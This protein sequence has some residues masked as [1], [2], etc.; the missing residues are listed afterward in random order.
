MMMVMVMMIMMII[1]IIIIIIINSTTKNSNIGH[2]T[3]TTESTDVQAQ[4]YFTSEIT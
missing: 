4:N 1:I 3:H 2:C